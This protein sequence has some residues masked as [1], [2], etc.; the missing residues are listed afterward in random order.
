MMFDPTCSKCGTVI[1]KR[2]EVDV[3]MRFS[4]I[5]LE[6]EGTCPKCG[7]GFTWYE[8]FKFSHIEDI[9]EST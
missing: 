3:S 8:V 5:Q 9:E 6:C 1:E 4:R 7:T 2:I